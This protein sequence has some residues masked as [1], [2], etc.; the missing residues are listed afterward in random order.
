MKPVVWALVPLLSVAGVSMHANSAA[1]QASL[2]NTST[3]VTLALPGAGENP[4]RGTRFDWSGV[5]SGLEFEGHTWFGQWFERMDPSIH[6]F[7]YGSS[8]I[9]AGPCTAVTGPVEEFTA[10]LGYQDAA[11]GGTFVKIGV[12]VLRKPSDAKYDSF[13]LYEIADPAQWHVSRRRNMVRFQQE[14]GDSSSG[15]GY[16]YSK[17]VRLSDREPM[18]IIDHQLKNTGKRAIETDVYDHNFLV[19]DRQAPGPDITIGVPFQ[20]DA[21]HPPESNLAEFTGDHI[22]F[23]RQLSGEDRV[24][25]SFHG[26]GSSPSDYDIRIEDA[27]I[28]GGLRITGDR[29][30]SNA[31][32][33]AIRSVLAVEPF[34]NIAIEPGKTA[35]WRYQYTFYKLESPSR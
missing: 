14:I 16:E 28:G 21:I 9:I 11:V 10:A 34:V 1:A 25:G 2:A 19:I 26:F 23:L 7:I 30:L 22:R 6:D 12:G 24:Y 35:T 13:H 29:P 5:I 31:A 8:G 27:R 20:I 15:F 4:Y 32:V 17:T 18:L 3:R 33:W